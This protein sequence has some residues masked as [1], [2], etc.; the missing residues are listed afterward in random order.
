[1]DPREI[2]EKIKMKRIET[3]DKD[4]KDFLRCVIASKVSFYTLFPQRKWNA[5][6][7]VRNLEYATDLA[8]SD[9]R[10]KIFTLKR[11]SFCPCPVL[12]HELFNSNNVDIA[13]ER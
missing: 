4:K 9:A 10:V 11:H 5:L 1:M 6:D 3:S 2:Q 7:R 8:D 12:F 13:Y